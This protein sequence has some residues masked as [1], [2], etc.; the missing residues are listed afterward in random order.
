MRAH[1][2]RNDKQT[3]AVCVPQPSC[4]DIKTFVLLRNKHEVRRSPILLSSSLNRFAPY[5]STRSRPR[6]TDRGRFHM[7]TPPEDLDQ[8]TRYSSS[9]LR[10]RYAYPS[11][12]RQDDTQ[13]GRRLTYVSK[14]KSVRRSISR[15]NHFGSLCSQHHLRVPAE[16]IVV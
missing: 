2:P 10:H 4:S 9:N 13:L 15:L 1:E 8:R 6:A 7:V 14:V 12:E 11:S 5:W 16:H 3:C